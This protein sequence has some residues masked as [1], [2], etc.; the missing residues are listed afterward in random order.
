MRNIIFVV[1]ISELCL[2]VKYNI[3]QYA[4]YYICR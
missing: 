2:Y 1:S 3:I 4:K